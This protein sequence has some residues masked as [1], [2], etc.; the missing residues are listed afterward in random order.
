MI[1]EQDNGLTALFASN[2]EARLCTGFTFTEGPIWIPDDE[3]LLF[4]DIPGNRIHR[5]R[6]GSS[7]AE[8]YREPSGHSN[9]L[10]LDLAGNLLACEHGGRRVSIARYNEPAQ[11]L[12]DRYKNGRFHSPNDIVVHSS[13]A[14]YFTDPDYG[15]TNENMGDFGAARELGHLGVYRLDPD[16]TLTL[17]IDGFD[18]PNGLVFSPDEAILYVNDSR[19]R[20]INR[21]DVQAD[22]SLANEELFVDMRDSVGRGAPDGMKVDED[23][24]LWTTGVG[25]VWVVDQ[26]GSLLGIFETAEHAANL[27]WGGRQFSTLYLT[28]Q[29]SVYSVESNVRGIAPGSR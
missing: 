5:W 16:G 19:Q 23:G 13:G 9:G 12:V 20:V 14:I 24:R 21:Y 28:A 6:P 2:E 17:L 11:T 26:E 27:N 15:L 8:V 25:G 29:T 22:G 18:G 1:I 4:S 3:C 10:T 7:E